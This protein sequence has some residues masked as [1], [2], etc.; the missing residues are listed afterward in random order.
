M[1]VYTYTTISDP[2]AATD[3]TVALGLNDSD[4][5][6]R[7]YRNASGSHG[8]LDSGLDDP[9]ANQGTVAYGINSSG[10]V[11]AN[12]N[13][14]GHGFLNNPNSQTYTTLDDPLATTGT[15]GLDWQ[16]AGVGD[17]SGNAGVFLLQIKSRITRPTTA[18]SKT[19]AA[20][21]D[22]VAGWTN[23]PCPPAYARFENASCIKTLS[24]RNSIR[25]RRLPENFSNPDPTGGTQK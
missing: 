6:V 1:P 11:V 10:M 25:T 23:S 14:G 2:S 17:F 16:V 12:Y 9:S 18:I 22:A 7:S 19:K 3:T 4:Q 5:I 20:R 13:D 15:V 24:Y 21:R 8:F